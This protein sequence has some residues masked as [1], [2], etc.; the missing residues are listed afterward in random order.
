MTHDSCLL[1]LLQYQA[2]TDCSIKLV[3]T[4]FNYQDY[5]YLFNIQVHGGTG[6]G[7]RGGAITNATQSVEAGS[8]GQGALP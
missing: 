7:C 8:R 5:V 6:S 3:G 2:N 1:Y 4:D